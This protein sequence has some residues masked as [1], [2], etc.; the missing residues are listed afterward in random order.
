MNSSPHEDLMGEACSIYEG[1]SK[2]VRIGRLERELEMVQ[3]CA[4]RCS[5]IAILSQSS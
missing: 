3:L 4:T 2:S 5:C 1:V